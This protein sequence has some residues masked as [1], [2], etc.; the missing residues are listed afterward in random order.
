M[1]FSKMLGV[2]T[3]TTSIQPQGTHE[4]DR[5]S[6]AAAVDFMGN[7]L[8]AIS[9]SGTSRMRGDRRTL[10]RPRMKPHIKVWKGADP[11]MWECS[12][13]AARGVI[14]DSP[15]AAFSLFKSMFV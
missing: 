13:D 11:Q 6:M 3:M 9:E 4:M 1:P 12:V 15:K 2:P 8:A 10:Q 5:N 14:A 7:S